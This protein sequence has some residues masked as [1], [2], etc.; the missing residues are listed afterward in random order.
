M[1]PVLK[2]HPSVPCHGTH[3]S[4]IHETDPSAGVKETTVSSLAGLWPRLFLSKTRVQTTNCPSLS[5]GTLVSLRNPEL[6]KHKE[7]L[8]NNYLNFKPT[9]YFFL[10]TTIILTIDD[11]S[12][13][14]FLSHFEALLIHPQ[15]LRLSFKGMSFSN[16]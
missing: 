4:H 10:V 12:L 13:T 11:S 14:S 2:A 7:S 6:L 5:P 15:M 9:T 8:E 16:A 1:H 3:R